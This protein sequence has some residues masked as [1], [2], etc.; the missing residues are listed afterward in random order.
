M[1]GKLKGR[2]DEVGMDHAIIDVGGVGYE[3]HCAPRTI[4]GL[5]GKGEAVELHIE[6]TMRE[7]EI[8]LFAFMSRQEREWFRTLQTVQGV[9]AKLALAVLSALTPTE[10][11]NAIAFKDMKAITKAPGVGPK[12][13]QRLVMEL[14]DKIPA[15][16]GFAPG[17]VPAGG[18]A[19]AGAVQ[20]VKGAAAFDAVSALTNLG[21]PANKASDAVAAALKK[22]G[23]DADLQTLI[24]LALK[25]LAG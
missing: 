23:D 22:A 7:T 3:V 12:V 14:K 8:R 19:A 15:V 25:A 11:A 4:A 21:Y 16:T 6:T 1:I 17:D 13:A 10:L 2:V 20:P 5:P 9:G 18:M 24:R